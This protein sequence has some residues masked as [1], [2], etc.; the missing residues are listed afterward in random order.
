MVWAEMVMG[1]NGHGPKWLWAEMTSDRLFD[2][3][4]FLLSFFI[5]PYALTDILGRCTL[6]T[7]VFLQ[8]EPSNNRLVYLHVCRVF[9]LHS[10]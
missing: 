6:Y 7:P 10:G 8:D 9:N 1:R 3:S 4:V 5:L 2:K